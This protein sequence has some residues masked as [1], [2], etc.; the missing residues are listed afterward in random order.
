M[1]SVILCCG[2][3]GFAVGCAA[4]DDDGGAACGDGVCNAGET[5]ATCATDC[6]VGGPFCGDGTCNGNE[7]V[8]T[9]ASDCSTTS[10]SSSPDT[11]TGETICIS[12]ACEA[13]FPRVYRIANVVASMPT[14]NPNNGQDWDVGG[15][16]PD[17]YLG[18]PS[19]NPITTAIADQFNATFPGPFEISLIAGGTLRVDVW[20]EDISSHDFA[21]GCQANPITSALLRSR[22]LSC[23][24]SGASLSLAINPK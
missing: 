19:G 1:K 20:D 10:C 23:A 14:K 12:G 15:G 17:L 5:S 2:L 9:C 21:F 7:S 8:S 3:F 16:A 11:C 6:P 18:D 13:A 22:T 24:M 4:D